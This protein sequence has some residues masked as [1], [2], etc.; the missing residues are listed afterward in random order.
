MRIAILT[1]HRAHNCGA[2]LQAWALKKVLERM[3]HEVSF[4]ACNS[5]G[6]PK[7]RWRVSWL[8]PEKK[9]LAA[10]RAMFGRL[11]VNL[12]SIPA[13]DILRLR[14]R[15]FRKRFLLE[16]W[17]LPAEFKEHYDLLV[18]GSDQIWNP[19]V[20]NPCSD[21]FFME[22]PTDVPA[23]AYAASIGDRPLEGIDRERLSKAIS[24]FRR[25]SVREPIAQDQIRAIKGVDVDITLDPTL[26]LEAADYDE[27]SS[28]R[29]IKEDYL[30]LYT[31]DSSAFYID[32]ARE[33]ARRLGVRCV[34]A[35]CYQ[36][37]RFG[38]SRDFIYSVSPDQLVRYACYAKY[39]LAGSFHGTVM[40]LLFGKSVLSLRGQKDEYESRPAALLK[41]LG[42]GNRVVF[43]T[44]SI[45][46]MERLLREPL[47]VC[48]A[49]LE[50]M[51][52]DSLRWLRDAIGAG[53][54]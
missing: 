5:V 24:R 8:N 26:L 9:G 45:N 40:G 20:A 42:C 47:G 53:V 29:P 2:M 4:P 48:S 18:Y 22:K 37:S 27:L 21:L 10:L 43:P 7:S 54:C 23:I 17:C 13:E 11:V 6:V 16:C 12:M 46:E 52:R 49:A 36:Y 25:V 51:R 38:A 15:R 3:G 14:Y 33:L 35:D 41:R 32:T 19:M 50:R 28:T 34:I 31:L 39:V 30:L 1:F 44:T